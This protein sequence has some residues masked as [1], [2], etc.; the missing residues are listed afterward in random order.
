MSSNIPNSMKPEP[1]QGEADAQS[2]AKGTVETGHTDI[3]YEYYLQSQ[4]MDPAQREAIAKKVLRKI[5]FILLPAMCLVY[6]L[7]FLDKQ[8]LNYSNAY[9]LQKDLGL[10]GRDYS[11]VASITNIGYLV[12]SYPSSWC[13]QR[14]PIGKFVSIMILC[15]GVLLVATVGAKNFAGIMTLRFILGGL[16]ACIGPAWMLVTSMFWTR[17]EQ[18]LR[19]CIWL[20]CNGISL[21]LGSGISWG[22]GTTTHTAL[23]SWQLIFLVIGVITLFFGAIAFFFFPSSPVDCKFFTHEERVVS[24]WRVADNHTGI[25]HSQFLPYQMKEAFLEPRVWC[26]ALQQISIGIINGSITN[27]MSSLLKGFGYDSVE[28]ITWQLPNGAFQ[29]VCTVIAG[30]IASRFRNMT[31]LMSVLVQ[32]PSL[33]G[34]IG[35]A[36]IPLDHRLALTACCWLLGIIG[37]AIILNWSI[38]AS[39]FAGHSKRMTVNGLNF[40]C[41]AGGNII[42]PFMF[43]PDESPRYMSAIKALCGVY[44]SCMFFTA[45]IGVL[46]WWENKKRDARIGSIAGT[47]ANDGHDEAEANEVGFS[48]RTDKENPH[49]RYKL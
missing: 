1:A 38:V 5:D 11:W 42:G 47:E 41:Y 22:L 33:A 30:F 32:V 21:M 13:L 7:S 2:I 16:E 20:G 14:F 39:N 35:I 31:V 12:F 17:D 10:E 44:A 28:I 45:C 27:F 48:D 6:L 9:G 40:I 29:L 23:A 24:V 49:F 8:T 15:W 18:P 26:V 4:G 19:M 37:A 3:G 43:D 34:I 36:L 25:K 46:M